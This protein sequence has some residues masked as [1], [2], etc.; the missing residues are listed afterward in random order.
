ME[1][2]EMDQQHPAQPEPLGG[3]GRRGL[4]DD[5]RQDRPVHALRRD[6]ERRPGLCSFREPDYR[7]IGR[8]SPPVRCGAMR[9]LPQRLAGPGT[10]TRVKVRVPQAPA[11]GH[12]W[13]APRPQN[14]RYQH[15][16]DRGSRA[17]GSEPGPG[18]TSPRCRRPEPRFGGQ[19]RGSWYR[20]TFPG[21]S[22]Q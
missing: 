22:H 18:V 10:Y 1:F 3:L 5:R 11:D 8:A 19:K 9:C 13:S 14:A 15:R 20:C 4:E 16:R 21:G 2:D 12:P 7:S 17:A 6:Q